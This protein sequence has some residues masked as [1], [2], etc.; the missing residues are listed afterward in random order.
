MIRLWASPDW[1]EVMHIHK[2]HTQI[3]VQIAFIEYL[4][5]FAKAKL[6][7]NWCWNEETK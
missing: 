4:L 7:V 5:D 2:M 3:N 6:V 1:K